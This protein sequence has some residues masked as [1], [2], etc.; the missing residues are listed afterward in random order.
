[1]HTTPHPELLADIAREAGLQLDAES[2]QSVSGGDISAAFRCNDQS[3]RHWF[4]KL[5]C[6]TFADAFAAEL[7]GLQELHRAALRSPRALAY[8]VCGNSAWLVLEWL[9]MSAGNGAAALLGEQLAAMH[10]ITAEQHGWRR[11]NYIGST[12]QSNAPHVDWTR[13]FATQR[14]L[15]QL[16][17][18]A[19]NHAPAALIERG[20]SLVEQ[21]P[22]RLNGYEPEPSLLHGD[23]WGGNWAQLPGGD[24]VIFDPA[25]YYGDRE[26]DLAMT[27]LFGGFPAEFYR[28]YEQA[29]PLEDGHEYR[30]TLY[31]LYHVINH[32]N[33]FGGA[34]A[35]QAERMLDALLI[36]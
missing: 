23:L 29:W 18:A 8:G 5:N 36:N 17:L 25:V 34:Y 22:Q 11:D 1:M 24:P 13:F 7:A 2:C 15:A 28:A 33:I 3:G 6:N 10:R 27:R 16:K 31:Q 14:L 30:Q 4:L 9:D 19:E 26:A 21:L 12:P 32:F 35:A 20:Q